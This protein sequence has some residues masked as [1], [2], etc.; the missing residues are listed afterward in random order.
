MK[1]TG[2]WIVGGMIG[3]LG[4]IGLLV[5]AHAEDTPMYLVGIIFFLFA[6]LFDAWLVK[7]S[8]DRAA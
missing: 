8:F 3:V 5:A 4:I 1:G 2:I 6:V 7:Q